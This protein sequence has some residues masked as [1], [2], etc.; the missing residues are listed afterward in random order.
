M[1]NR[2]FHEDYEYCLRE[3]IT[4]INDALRHVFITSCF[5]YQI[6][7]FYYFQIKRKSINSDF[8]LCHSDSQFHQNELKF[9]K[10]LE[11]IK[12]LVIIEQEIKTRQIEELKND[13]I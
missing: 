8:S 11:Q 5:S 6:S 10:V 4:L 9:S 3:S 2:E 13:E 1:E 7:Y 12:S